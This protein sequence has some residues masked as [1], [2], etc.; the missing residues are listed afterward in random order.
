MTAYEQI[1]ALVRKYGD[2]ASGYAHYANEPSVLVDARAALLAAV[3]ALAEDAERYRHLR[4]K[5]NDSDVE[6]M[7]TIVPEEWDAA[8]D[9]NRQSTTSA[10]DNGRGDA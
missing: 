7:A 10:A 8:I 3:K 1:E 6:Y 4:D 2:E 5:C 9:S